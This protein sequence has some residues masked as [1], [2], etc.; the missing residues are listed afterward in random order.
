MYIKNQKA[1]TMVELIFVIII[2][3]ILSAVAIPKFAETTKVA[4]ESS[5]ESVV[6]ALRSVIATERQKNILKGEG[7]HTITNAE[8][9]ALLRYGWDDSTWATTSTDKFTY[10]APW[11][12]SKTCVF[13]INGG[14]LEKDT[15]DAA[16]GLDDL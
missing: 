15:C 1:F 12:S 6:N 9:K 13:K 8:A 4:Y 3:G 10:T 14:K 7:S 16:T 2:I 11:D 5:A